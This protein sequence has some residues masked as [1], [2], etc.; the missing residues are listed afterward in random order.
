MIE[1][2]NL[3]KINLLK[4]E[5]I[6]NNLPSK[7]QSFILQNTNLSF[8]DLRIF[9]MMISDLLAWQEDLSYLDNADFSYENFK[10]SYEN[11]KKEPYTL[12][13]KTFLKQSQ[14]EYNN[15]PKTILG[16]CPVASLKT[17]CCNLYTLDT[18]QGCG[19]SCAYCAIP[20]FYA[21][22]KTVNLPSNLEEVLN[23]LI[24]DSE[25]LYHI[26][27]GQAGDSLLYTFDKEARLLCNFANKHKAN[28]VLELKSKSSNIEPFLKLE[29][30]KNMVFTWSLNPNEVA[31][32]LEGGAVSLQHRL[33]S[34]KKMVEHGAKIGFHIHPVVPFLG[35]EKAYENLVTQVENQ[36]KT[37]DIVMISLGTLTFS[38]RTI[39]Y[40]RETAIET[41]LLKLP[42]VE[43]ASKFSFD[44]PTKEKMFSHVFNCFSK[45]FR[46]QIYFYLCMEDESL[47][48]KTLG[49][50]YNNNDDFEKD[51]LMSYRKKMDII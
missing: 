50:S 6:F 27:T 5:K 13:K 37:D 15:Y 3:K 39:K 19:F 2:N 30:P 25:K 16:R 12:P 17:R 11:L 34:A 43:S 49:K 32:S 44:L 35:Y 36:F 20:T 7:Y 21:G 1:N 18:A 9:S 33:D 42:F 14:V 4:Q 48:Q 38:K 47:W 24:I 46:E 23:D 31:N 29:L 26:G 41:N 8:S 28:V 51:M 45:E 22:G 40:I 10:T